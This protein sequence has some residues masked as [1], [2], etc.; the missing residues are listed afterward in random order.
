MDWDDDQSVQVEKLEHRH[1][2]G[3]EYRGAKLMMRNEEDWR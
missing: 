3:E 1:S 2:V